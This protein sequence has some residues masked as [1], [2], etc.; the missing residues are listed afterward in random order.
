MKRVGL[1]EA[2]KLYGNMGQYASDVFQ[3][4]ICRGICVCSMDL[5]PKKV[6]VTDM[7]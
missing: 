5:R 2:T 3:S 4:C 1:S 6:Y 7:R